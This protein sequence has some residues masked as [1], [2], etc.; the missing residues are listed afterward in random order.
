[1]ASA[2]LSGGDDPV[3]DLLLRDE[4][5]SCSESDERRARRG[6]RGLRGSGRKFA[7][8]TMNGICIQDAGKNGGSKFLDTAVK[9]M[10]I[11]QFS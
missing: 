9:G 4:G 1:M 3:S 8:P 2:D 7:G 6:R 10:G 5:H 11:L